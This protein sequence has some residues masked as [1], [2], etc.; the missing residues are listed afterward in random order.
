MYGGNIRLDYGG[1]DFSMVFQG[2]GKQNSQITTSMVKPYKSDWG[3]MPMV[4]DGKY[5]SAYNTEEQNLNARYPRLTSA[6]AENNYV[7]SDFWLFNG[8]YFRM[9]NITL[10]YTLPQSVT[11]PVHLQNVRVY[12]SASD[13]F[14][15]N[16]YPKGWDPETS[17]TG[18]P[19]TTSIV[20]GVSIKF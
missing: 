9:K 8:A 3:N 14:S 5:W 18:Y 15:I 16:N 6:N 1:F 7:M 10:G 19:I 12:C 2:V 4:I 17:S 11:K 20:Y 13:L